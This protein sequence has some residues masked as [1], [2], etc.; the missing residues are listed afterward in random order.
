MALELYGST[1]SPYVRRIRMLLEGQDFDFHIVNVY[2]AAQ[3]EAFSS[4][5][6][7]RKLPALKADGELIYDSGV[8]ASYLLAQSGAPALTIAQHNLISAID[9]ATDSLIINFQSKNSGLTV[10][11]QKLFY[12]LQASRIKVC[13]DWLEAQAGEGVFESW[14]Y[15]TIALISLWDWVA[16]RDLYDLSLYPNL[17]SAVAAYSDREGVKS[18]LPH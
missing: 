13:F 10:D 4:V 1:T 17:S 2:D 12:D 14:S 15:P 9:A 7:I 5:S 3:R 11:E 18:T 16:F 6:P 8:I